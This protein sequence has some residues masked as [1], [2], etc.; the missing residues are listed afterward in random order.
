MAPRR[1]KVT[2]NV[3]PMAGLVAAVPG[4]AP[5]VVGAQ[6]AARITLPQI[7]VTAS[8]FDVDLRVGGRLREPPGEVQVFNESAYA[9]QLTIGPDQHYLPPWIGH[10]Y[11]AGYASMHVVPLLLTNPLPPAPSATLLVTVAPQGDAFGGTWPAP[12]SRHSSSYSQPQALGL[13]SAAANQNASKS[14]GLPSGL[15]CIGFSVDF[16]GGNSFPFE[17]QV[18]GDQTATTYLDV[19]HP[20]TGVY[21]AILS[22]ADTSVTLFLTGG[23]STTAVRLLGWTSQIVS[24]ASPTSQ[25]AAWQAPNKVPQAF[26]FSLAAG[27]S[28][29]VVSGQTDKVVTLFGILSQLPAAIPG[30]FGEWQTTDGFTLSHVDLSQTFH[31]DHNLHGGALS[32]GQGLAFKNTSGAA[33]TASLQGTVVYG[34]M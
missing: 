10:V 30:C 27:A 15:A 7:T 4:G 13:V 6:T 31:V 2:V 33:M 3:P 32:V 1:R 26:S 17:V 8:P 22:P 16:S 18:T 11:R 34:R 14:I 28:S 9:L 19:T 20:E 23:P 25:P 24:I 12:A 5:P 29:T 21:A